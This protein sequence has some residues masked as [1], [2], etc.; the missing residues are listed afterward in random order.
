[1]QQH[2]LTGGFLFAMAIGV[3]GLGNANCGSSSAVAVDAPTN[4]SYSAKASVYTVGV[5]I[6]ENT[7]T[8]GGG[9]VASYSVSP[10]LPGGLNLSPSTGIISGTPTTVTATANYFVTATNTGGSASATVTITVND[11]APANLTYAQ[12]PAVYTVGTP[13]VPNTPSN[14]GG[15][16]LSYSGS[17]AAGLTV[18]PVTGVITGTPTAVS[19][20]VDYTVIAINSGG[21]TTGTVTITVNDLAPSNLTYSTSSAVY[22]V[23][24]AITPNT[25]TSSGGNVGSYSVSPA[26]PAGLSLDTVTG[27]ISGTPTA[28]TASASYTVT[29]SNFVGKATD[30]ITIKVDDVPP[31]GLSYSANPAVYTVGAAIPSNTPTHGGGAVVSYAVSPALPA[32]LTLNTTSG[33]ISGTPTAVTALTSYTVTA[34][35]TGGST[36]VGI[37][38]TVNAVMPSGLTYS[39][40]PAVYTKGVAIPANTPSHSGGAIVSYAVSPPLPAGLSL[41]TTTG[42]I[43]G[44]PTAITPPGTYTVTGTNSGGTITAGVG[45]TVNDVAPSSLTYS[46]NPAVYTVGT[47]ITPNSPSHGGGAVVYYSVSP[48][49]PPG[50]ALSSSTGVISGTPATITPVATYTVTATNTG[51]S[52]TAGVTITVNDVAPSGLTY[53]SN[54]AVYSVGTAI[55]ANTPSHAGGAVVSY[56]VSP[57]LPAG[58][59]LSTTTGVISG[60]PTTV[61][62]LAT[63][64]VTATNTGG[65]TTVGVTITVDDV[66]PSGLTYSTN[67]AVYTKG[68]TIAPNTPS[69]GGGTVVSYSV[70]PALPAGLALSPTSGV[71]SGTPTTI[72]GLATYT[73]TATN[74]GGSTTA[75]VTI[76]VNDAAP[77]GLT[78]PSN[79]AVYT[80]GT[81]IP[82]NTPTHGGGAVVS[83]AVSPPLPAG[84]GLNLTTGVISGT[85]TTITPLAT[86]TVTATNTGG[87]TAVG[88]TITVNDVAPSGL[89]YSSNPAVYTVGTAI[90]ANTPT[91]GGGAVVS[92]VVSPALPAGLA[93]S[94]STGVISGTPTTV[95]AVATYTVTA[96]NTGGSTTAGVT[97]TVNDVAPSGLTYSSNPAVYSVGAVITPNSPSHGGG[98]VISYA[99]SP[100]LPAGL[101]LSPSTGVI[102]GTPT[103]VTA[104][105]TYTV[106]ATNTGGSTTVGVTITV[107]DTAPTGL[108]YS[109]NPAVY[110]VGTAIPGNTPSHGGGAVISYAVSPVLPA[111]LSL[112]STTG[113]ISGTPTTVTALATYTVTATN[114]GGSTTV[115]VS[116]TV[117]DVAPSGLTY[118]TNPAVYTKGVTIPANTPSHSGGAVVSYAVSPA[119][120]TGLGLSPTTGVISGTP[121]T[122]TALATYTVTATNTGGSTTVGVSITV[123]DVAPS[124][125]AYSTNPAVYTLGTAIASNTPTSSGGA[126]VSYAVSPAL[127][128]G[129]GLSTT[130]GIISGTPTAVTALATY[131]VTATNTGGST[132]VGVSITVNDVA[133]SGLTYSSNPA[134][135][136]VGTAI[137]A[138]SPSHGGG[139]V[140]SYAVSPALPAGLG[141][142]P[143]TGVI[144]GTPTTVT[145]LATY[146]VTAT[147]TGGSTTVGVTIT[148]NDVAPS[149]LAY[150][151]NPAVYTVGTAIASNT[152]TSSGGAVVSYAVSPPLPAGLGLSPTTGVISGTPTAIT[153]LATY[154]VTATN[155]GG[156]TTVGVSITV[157][158][159]APS[160]LTYSANPAVYTVGTAITPNTPTSTGGAVVSYAVSPPLP[161]GLS[162][163]PVAGAISG[164]PTAATDLAAYTVTATNTGGS[165]TASVTITV[166]DSS[167]SISYP[168]NPA[169]YTAGAAIA[170]NVPSVT[171][172]T[173]SSYS[174]S[175]A[176]PGGL[177]LDPVAGIIS[178]TPTAPTP[179][180][181]YN[182]TAAHA[183]GSVSTGVTITVNTL[184]PTSFAFV[185]NGSDGTLS[186]YTVNASTGQ[187]RANGYV[188]TGL[189]PRAVSIHP[190]GS[191]AYVTGSSS[192]SNAISAFTIN[193]ATGTVKS[194]GAVGTG[195]QPSAV[196][197][198]SSGRFAYVTNLASNDVSAFTINGTTGS[199][200]SVGPTIAAGTGPNSVAIDPSG[201]FV[202]VSSQASNTVSAYTINASTGALTSA[203]SPV[204]TGQTPSSVRVDASGRFVYVANQTSND[205]SAYAINPSTGGLTS[206]GP[207]VAAGNGPSAIGT[208]VTGHFAYAANSVDGTVSAYAINQSTG[209]LTSLGPAVAAGTGP[210]SI[211]VDASGSFVYVANTGVANVSV[212]TI[213]K[214]NGTL[215]A[216]QTMATRAGPASVA[217]VQRASAVRYV[218]KFAYVTNF[219]ANTIWSYA[220]DPNAGALASIGSPVA[221]GMGPVSVSVDPTG[222]YAY[223]ANA[224][225]GTVSAYTIDAKAGTLTSVGSPVAS[226][227]GPASAT[228]DPSGAFLYVANSGANSLSAYTINPGTG[229]LSPVGSPVP[230]GL[231]PASVGVD[232][233][234]RFAYVANSGAN[235]VSAYGINASTGA[236]TSLGPDVA[237]GAQPMSVAVDPSGSLAY[238][239]NAA[240]GTVSVYTIN[241]SSGTL[242]PVGLAAPAGTQPMSIAVDP[243]G[244]FAFVANGGATDVS[245]FSIGLSNATLTSIGSPAV[246]T[247][248]M[249]VSVDPSGAFVYVANY[250]SASVSVYSLNASTGALTAVGVP[251]TAGTNPTSVVATGAL[252]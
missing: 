25:P 97:I 219:G 19:G 49:L 191:F 63:Y 4:L 180:A 183:G 233:S 1:M 184:Q 239:A 36:T 131:T 33:V 87:S 76:T 225:D 148:V 204:A 54:P 218:P 139:T 230:T 231:G 43:T 237:A 216:F 132:T 58:L 106:T 158:D 94:P 152:P 40:N 156:S 27:V 128:A 247:Q 142:S 162:L 2:R 113:V 55:P 161:A 124:G 151:T 185:G 8:V 67:P 46:S 159:V 90:P 195:S 250:G 45:I 141:L 238:V 105:A 168:A 11:A 213:N 190:S 108:T 35:N 122:V 217:L 211:T 57:A 196:A 150:S 203:G 244:G 220:I 228:V 249:S 42:V 200:T 227:A 107:N 28:V 214:A 48:A 232:P 69:H 71:I 210:S 73:V 240:D 153:A 166:N 223:V 172:G 207:T 95:T 88:V 169:E 179:T 47:A 9:K 72:T 242:L 187:L 171:G 133:P 50:L 205:I 246:G 163:D 98:A 39:S 114:T 13:I 229:G 193:A 56:A 186:L 70:S 30:R 31:S 60:T 251:A 93:L 157:N 53:S 91:H 208:E 61:T 29:A 222:S 155:T 22:T 140:V 235:T 111:G 15:K 66:A 44:T 10:A 6:P 245:A 84:L 89:T 121:T 209:A 146:T 241:A 160:G 64:T 80:V 38:I 123:N 221:T 137:P 85:P 79:P 181:S 144:S 101:A 62:A 192:S 130:T 164:T 18:D 7:P 212:Y 194:L 226:G 16:I 119:L 20:A 59:S 86:Y 21:H 234:G 52:T 17:V 83:Y 127:P 199:L 23:G 110:T 37:S 3:A 77:T 147:N 138:N 173:V 197:V 74:T 134:V 103:T 202:Y 115:G 120:P 26:L 118:S 125:L 41:N 99:V 75:G 143:T 174:V 201:R 224:S 51:G 236:L 126:V 189:N 65:S 5:L 176:L 116:I 82:S 92:Y 145:A 167:M 182:V 14:S 129:L 215:S 177:S 252:Q 112:S 109:S 12:N 175:P 117:N 81:A 248:P 165:T 34:T 178:G 102:S 104:L 243:W 206:V 198:D 135:Y 78:Y 154:T 68:V 24:T 100:A 32:G 96:T 170:V 136:T 188:A 149:G